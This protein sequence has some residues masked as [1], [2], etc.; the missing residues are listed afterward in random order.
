MTERSTGDICI[1]WGTHGRRGAYF[2]AQRLNLA[3]NLIV[4]ILVVLRACLGVALR[5]QRSI[6]QGLQLVP[7]FCEGGAEFFFGLPQLFLVQFISQFDLF[8]EFDEESDVTASR[9]TPGL[10]WVFSFC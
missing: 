1:G 8:P 4:V 10:A 9:W 7:H 3:E 5:C 6:C 2:F